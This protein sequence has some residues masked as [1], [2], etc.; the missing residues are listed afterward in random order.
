MVIESCQYPEIFSCVKPKLFA[1]QK[2]SIDTPQFLY[3]TVSDLLAV[4]TQRRRKKTWKTEG[5]YVTCNGTYIHTYT[6]Y[7]SAIGDTYLAGK[8]NLN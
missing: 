3:K 7:F 8:S 1:Q 4:T 6:K 5:M 2:Q